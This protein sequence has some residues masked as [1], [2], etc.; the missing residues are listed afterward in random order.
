VAAAHYLHYL[1]VKIR[2]ALSSSACF[3][4]VIDILFPVQLQ[5]LPLLIALNLRYA[6]NVCLHR[7]R[8]FF[9]DELVLRNLVRPPTVAL[10]YLQQQLMYGCLGPH[11]CLLTCTGY[12]CQLFLLR[13]SHV[14]DSG[15]WY[16]CN[17]SH[18]ENAIH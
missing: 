18:R 5:V 9:P 17:N 8:H 3:L 15:Q 2:L 6:Q 7:S 13:R 16:S 1:F 11:L 4:L 10:L 12:S 14:T